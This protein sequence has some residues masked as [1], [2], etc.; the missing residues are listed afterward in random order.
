MNRLCKRTY[1]SLLVEV[2]LLI[3]ICS[4]HLLFNQH[5]FARLCK[6]MCKPIETAAQKT[7]K[8]QTDQPS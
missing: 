4:I 6:P 8:L 3:P 1:L 2:V 7:D 5:C